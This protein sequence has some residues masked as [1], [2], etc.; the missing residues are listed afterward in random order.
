MQ[1]LFISSWFPNRL[2]PTNGN[3]VQRHAEAVSLLHDVEILHVVGDSTQKQ[4]Y[5]FEEHNINGIKTLI[6][7]YR[8]TVN[9]A[10]NFLRRVRAYRLGVSRLHRPDLVHAN[11]MDKS[12]LF[13]VYLKK[14]YHIP[15]VITEHW[16]SFLEINREKLSYSTLCIARFI[17]KNALFI[18]PVSKNLM[19]NLKELKIGKCFKVIGNVV[20]TERF[21]PGPDKPEI[22]TFLH[23]SNLI[24]L[25]N[26]DAI[27]KVAVRLRSEFKNFELRIGG[28][29]NIQRLSNIIEKNKAEEFIKIFGERT[30][31]EVAQEM[32]NSNCFILFS[33]HES[34]S[35]V[36]LESIS[37]G[38]PVITTSVG[39]APEVVKSNCGIIIGKSEEELYTAMKSVLTGI[40]QPDPPTELHE[41][42][43]ENFSRMRIAKKF[44]EIYKQVI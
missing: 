17:A 36:I 2:E 21:A 14:K 12:M 25:K 28:D 22:F 4:S 41:Y 26:P 38:V 20:D 35:C 43:E 5:I 32:K 7:Y 23:I 3:F 10:V 8:K 44:D 1:I 24:P 31:D 37:T 16:S 6:I 33:E 19:D 29:G 42:I 30:Y 11:I 40:Y 27:I 13:A 15:F 9:P 34:F 18:L 39:V